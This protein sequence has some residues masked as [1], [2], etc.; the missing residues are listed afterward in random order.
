MLCKSAGASSA[1]DAVYQIVA[2]ATDMLHGHIASVSVGAGDC[3]CRVQD[4][5]ISASASGAAVPD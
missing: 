4:W 1:S 3:A 2:L 5:A